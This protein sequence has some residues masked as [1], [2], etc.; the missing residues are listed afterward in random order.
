VWYVDEY[1]S[2]R[3]CTCTFGPRA[4][5]THT[6]THT[7]IIGVICYAISCGLPTLFVVYFASHIQAA[8]PGAG[9][10]SEFAE[11][12]FG[13]R[14]KGVVLGVSMLNMCVGLLAEL[15]T[16]GALFRDFVGGGALPMI[17][18]SSLLATCYTAYGGLLVSIVTDQFQALLSLVLI[19][20]VTVYTALTFRQDLPSDLG[21]L[22]NQLGP[23]NPYGI[24]SL[25]VMPVCL[26]A[27]TVIP[28]C[29]VLAC[30]C[31]PWH[32]R[33]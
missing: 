6:H 29:L 18:V 16:I 19:S 3:V 21:P 1:L 11:L 24:S 23:H 14:A 17:L 30:P 20:A 4:T 25:F 27:S 7:G 26:L 15:T 9:S 28:V 5:R 13:R 33:P 10:L 2:L 31:A 32:R 8:W 12:R 22:A